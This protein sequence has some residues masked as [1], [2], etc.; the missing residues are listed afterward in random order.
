MLG[1]EDSSL[2]LSLFLTME[3]FL[4]KAST[5]KGCYYVVFIA[6]GGEGYCMLMV[7]FPTCNRFSFY[8]ALEFAIPV[9][10]R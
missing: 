4:E 7:C 3:E 2:I 6:L 9:W 5:F 10:H 1:S 8:L